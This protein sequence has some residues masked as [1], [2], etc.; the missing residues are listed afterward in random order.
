MGWLGRGVYGIFNAAFAESG[1]S[2]EVQDNED[3]TAVY[4]VHG[5]SSGTDRALLINQVIPMRPSGVSITWEFT[6]G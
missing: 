2:L 6:N 4:K 3:M 1:L 5:A